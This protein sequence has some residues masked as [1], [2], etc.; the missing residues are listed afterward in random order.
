MVGVAA[1]GLAAL[2]Y[3]THLY[4]Y[5]ALRGAGTAWRGDLAQ[6]TAHFG[7]WA[8]LTPLVLAVAARRELP[9][10]RWQRNL[11]LHLLTAVA[12]AA[13]QVAL[14]TLVEH[15]WIHRGEGGSAALLSHFAGFFSRT[16]YANVLLYFALVL[17]VGLW[18]RAARARSREADLQRHLVQA[19]LEA[20]RLRLQPHFLF[21]ALHAISALVPDQPEKAQRMVA[22]LADLLRG[23]LATRAEEI[24]L[25][26][27][28][29]LARA[30]LDV[31][32]VRF[33]DRLAVSVESDPA[34]AEALVPALL[35]QPLIEN[36]IR[37]GIARRPGAGRLDVR[38]AAAAQ[39]LVLAVRDDGQGLAAAETG[40][41]VGLGSLR[42]RLE[43]LYEGRASLSLRP[44]P[45]GGAETVVELPLRL[46]AAAREAA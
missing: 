28:L 33:E 19:Q 2:V 25:R 27:E 30:Y 42:A 15:L 36:A 24:P 18:R 13:V 32:Q 22:R 17:G 14:H 16:Y 9:G 45:G 12:V 7:V 26:E 46:S 4:L 31:E 40:A 10:Y 37:H 38:A 44:L 23:V 34:L 3:S 11:P 5:H 20:L 39:R 29:A 35:L 8:L 21:N 41:G 43:R 6:A 1:W